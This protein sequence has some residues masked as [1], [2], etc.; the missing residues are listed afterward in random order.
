MIHRQ[1]M[2]ASRGASLA[3]PDVEVGIVYTHERQ[4]MNRL[5][6][7]LETASRGVAMRL[8]L[9]DNHSSE[10]VDSWLGH[11]PQTMVLRNPRRLGYA[12]NLN[13]ILRA[14]TARYILLLN[15]DMFFDPEEPCVTRMVRFMDSRPECGI[16]GCGLYHEDGRFA[17]PARRFQTVPVILARRFGL[18]PLMR[19][20][21][22]WY[23]YRDHA[24]QAT[25]E[26]DWL[27]G[28]FLMLRR[29]AAAQIGLFDERFGKYFED[30]DYCYRAARAGWKVLYHGA[31]Y[32][33]HLES[34]ASRNPLS[35]DALRHLRAYLRWLRKWGLSYPTVPA[36]TR[37]R[38]AA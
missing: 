20:T 34:R 10:G 3:N 38:R 25:W 6:T 8:I 32:C 13:R 2:T 11:V 5:L 33:F 26:A 35:V 30:V 24:P 28:A 23:L 18:G 12:A 17:Y 9:I 1:A 7:S 29:E 31:T 15:T 19:R 14:A 22:D 27:C 16:A 21:L 4:W 36:T 37:E